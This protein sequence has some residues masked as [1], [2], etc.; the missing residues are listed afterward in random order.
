MVITRLESRAK[1]FRL[2]GGE[3]LTVS[4]GDDSFQ[5]INYFGHMHLRKLSV[6]GLEV[7][8][9]TLKPSN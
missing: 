6:A 1:P 3:L 7:Q 5:K 2:I 4:S 8:A 9:V